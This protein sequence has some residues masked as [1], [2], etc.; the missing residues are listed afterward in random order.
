MDELTHPR[1][2]VGIDPSI[3][4]LAA[5]RTAVAEARHRHV[6]LYAVRCHNSEQPENSSAIIDAAFHEALGS[7]PGDIEIHPHT[8]NALTASLTDWAGDPRDLIVV[9]NSGKGMLRSLWSGSVPASLVHTA[10]CPILAVPAPEM[11]RAVNGHKHTHIRHEDL[12]DSFDHAA[13]E[14]SG[15]HRFN[16]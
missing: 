16:N 6:P 7:V 4:G 10:Q 13:P 15:K 14:L 9:G 3:H 11:A 1:V 2:V 5:L 8:V 12:W